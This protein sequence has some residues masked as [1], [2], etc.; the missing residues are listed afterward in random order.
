LRFP[1][2]QEVSSTLEIRNVTDHHV[3]FCMWSLNHTANYIAVPNIE[4][5]SPQSMRQVV[6]TRIA[7]R[8]P[9]PA[10][11]VDDIVYVKGTTVVQGTTS[12]D[13]TYDM[14][15]GTRTGQ[16]LQPAMELNVVLVADSEV[17]SINLFIPISICINLAILPSL[18]MCFY[19]F[20]MIRSYTKQGY[21]GP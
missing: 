1:V 15:D 20:F 12:A 21:H 11:P 16:I 2:A 9:V 4:V 18:D 14:F 8:E 7:R 5:L 17:R 6:I 3:A 19:C 13:V 10:D